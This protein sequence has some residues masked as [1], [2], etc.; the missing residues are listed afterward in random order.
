MLVVEV[1]I[2]EGRLWHVKDK[3]GIFTRVRGVE[4]PNVYECRLGDVGGMNEM[5]APH[6]TEPTTSRKSHSHS[7]V[8]SQ[9]PIQEA[10]IILYM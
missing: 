7:T 8:Y 1:K 9:D 4:V 10:V 6:P 2:F 3:A 5:I